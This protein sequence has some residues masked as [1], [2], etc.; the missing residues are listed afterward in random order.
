MDLITL[1]SANISFYMSFVL[2]LTLVI[3]I[4]KILDS[5]ECRDDAPFD[6]RAILDII[7]RFVSTRADW[8]YRSTLTISLSEHDR[9]LVLLHTCQSV[10]NKHIYGLY[11]N[12]R[13][14]LISRIAAVG[15]D[16]AQGILNSGMT[17]GSGQEL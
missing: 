10:L 15:T 16:K 7:L 3:A 12:Y 13:G 1:V 4:K 8:A 17:F 6:L 9:A 14:K 5:E 2:L 11:I